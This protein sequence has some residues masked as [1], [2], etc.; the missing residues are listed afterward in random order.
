MVFIWIIGSADA[1]DNGIAFDE[2]DYFLIAL[3][4]FIVFLCCCLTQNL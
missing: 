3:F 2:T 4:L 1:E